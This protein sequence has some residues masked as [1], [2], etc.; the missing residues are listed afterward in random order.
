M[1]NKVHSPAPELAYFCED[2]D[3]DEE[4]E[5]LDHE[6]HQRYRYS[7]CDSSWFGL[8]ILDYALLSQAGFVVKCVLA[9]EYH[10]SRRCLP[11]DTSIRIANN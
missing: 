4:F 7:I 2:S 10:A 1:G 11:A 8:T 3:A 6:A 5:V 9:T